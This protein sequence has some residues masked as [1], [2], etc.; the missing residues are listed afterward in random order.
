MSTS[1]LLCVPIQ[2]TQLHKTIRLRSDGYPSHCQNILNKAYT[3][4]DKIEELFS[5]GNLSILGEKYEPNTLGMHCTSHYQPNTCVAYLRDYDG[6]ITD[7]NFKNLT[8]KEI[9]INS[10]NDHYQ[11][12]DYVYKYN[13]KREKWVEVK[14]K[15]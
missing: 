1:A 12:I 5:N 15:K 10:Y 11:F 14:R 8:H 6:L 4:I 2:G 13:P 7:D 9:D 3:K